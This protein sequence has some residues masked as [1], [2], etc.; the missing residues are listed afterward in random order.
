MTQQMLLCQLSRALCSITVN[1]VLLSHS[2]A[3]L[4][5]FFCLQVFLHRNLKQSYRLMFL[6]LLVIVGGSGR[7][8]R[9]PLGF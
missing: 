8:S 4:F 9:L 1:K 5:P 6:I 7:L 3:D 2:E